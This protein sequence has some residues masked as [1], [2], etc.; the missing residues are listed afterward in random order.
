MDMIGGHLRALRPDAPRGHGRA[1][2]RTFRITTKV[3][4]GLKNSQ[5]I[6]RITTAC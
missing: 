3:L 5:D 1:E 2:G 4:L 6:E